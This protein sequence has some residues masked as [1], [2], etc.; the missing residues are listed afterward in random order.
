[1]IRGICDL[2]YVASVGVSVIGI[3]LLGQ[4]SPNISW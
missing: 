3:L 4:L 1:M 2:E